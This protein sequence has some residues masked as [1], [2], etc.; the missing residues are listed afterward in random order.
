MTENGRAQ[1]VKWVARNIRKLKTASQSDGQI[2]PVAKEAQEVVPM[3]N[4]T[5][6]HKIATGTG[7]RL[8]VEEKAVDP[9]FGQM[10]TSSKSAPC[11]PSP[12]EFLAEYI[13]AQNLV[14]ACFALAARARL[15]QSVAALAP[16]SAQFGRVRRAYV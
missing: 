12:L 14:V 13:E 10:P 6:V 11:A 4:T 16:K 2:L 8:R 9:E 1:L 15:A 5:P 7:K 3:D